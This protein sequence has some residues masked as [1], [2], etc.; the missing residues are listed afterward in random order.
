MRNDEYMNKAAIKSRF[1]IYRPRRHDCS[2]YHSSFDYVHTEHHARVIYFIF[3][4]LDVV[5]AEAEKE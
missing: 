2:V 3:A 5:L 4:W 1:N